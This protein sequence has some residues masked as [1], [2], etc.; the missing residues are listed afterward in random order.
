MELIL[1]GRIEWEIWDVCD[2]ICAKWNVFFCSVDVEVGNFFWKFRN[3]LINRD[4][5]FLAVKPKF[6]ILK[7][8]QFFENILFKK[9]YFVIK[10]YFFG[11][12][13]WKKKITFWRK[14]YLFW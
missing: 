1:W 3:V 7:N 2:E 12:I 14:N 4:P 13:T 5:F 9:N 11:N 10:N 6:F 8:P